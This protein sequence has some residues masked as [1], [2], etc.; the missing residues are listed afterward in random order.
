MCGCLGRT[1]G[2]A[3]TCDALTCVSALRRES[4]AEG[5]ATR[6]LVQRGADGKPGGDGVAGTPSAGGSGS[7]GGAA[8]LPPSQS[9]QFDPRSLL[10]ALPGGAMDAVIAALMHGSSSAGMTGAA[11]GDAAAAQAGG[12]GGAPAEGGAQVQQDR[13][14]ESL[15]MQACLALLCP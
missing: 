4:Y 1:R 10:S 8:A 14:L 12:E 13:G 15:L 3:R 5:R 11:G 2:P 9:G 6:A 7:G